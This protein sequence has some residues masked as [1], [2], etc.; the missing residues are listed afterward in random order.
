M[1][2]LG[3]RV[4]A[5]AGAHEAL[6]VYA[7]AMIASPST[8]EFQ[9]IRRRR[10]KAEYDDITIGRAEL[11]TDLAHAQEIIRAVRHAL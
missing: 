10:N 2:A 9:R 1:L 8:I 5:V 11:A 7:E 6:G 4:R 3:Y